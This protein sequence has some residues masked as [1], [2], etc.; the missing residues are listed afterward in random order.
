M[1]E[2]GSLEAEGTVSSGW[3]SQVYSRT[4]GGMGK[5]GSWRPGQGHSPREQQSGDSTDS[6]AQ[7]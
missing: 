6:N 5:S 2:Q 3:N 7:S 1:P 4:E